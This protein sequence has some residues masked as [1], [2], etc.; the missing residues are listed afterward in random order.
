[1]TRITVEIDDQLLA[2]AR[3]VLG[4]ETKVATINAALESVARR[5][6]VAEAIA[7]MNSVEMDYSGSEHSFRYG[8]GRDLGKLAERARLPREDPYPE[9]A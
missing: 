8:G 9:S 6:L 1:M 3:D 4:T 7:L 5:K 2:T